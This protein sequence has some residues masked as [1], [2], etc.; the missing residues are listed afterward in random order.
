MRSVFLRVIAAFSLA[1]LVCILAFVWV[2]ARISRL[3]TGTLMQGS[4]ELELKQA[5]KAYEG[6]GPE[7]LKAYLQEVDASLKGT[8][9][10]TDA[11]GR[12]LVYG[13]DRSRMR[14]VEFNLFGLPKMRHGQLTVSTPSPDG[15]YSLILVAPPPFSLWIFVPFF[16]IVIVVTGAL[17]FG[18][19]GDIVSPLLRLAGTVDRFGRGDLSARIE[20]NRRDEFGTVARSFNSMADRIETLLTAERRLLQDVSHELRSP[21]ARLSFATELLKSTDDRDVAIARLRRESDRLNRLVSALLEMSAAEG[22]PASRKHQRVDIAELVREIVEDC[23]IEASARDL[24]IESI[25]EPAVVDGDSELLR[26][27][28]EN[29]LRNAIRYSSSGG[30]V[31]LNLT[32]RDTNAEITVRDFGPG[33][34]EQK[35]GRIFDPFFR[36]DDARDAGNGGVGLGLSIARRAIVLHHGTVIAHN[37]SPGLEVQITIPTAFQI[38]A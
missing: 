4:S 15:K 11:Q 14:K 1:L 28:V 8:R 32:W 17:A 34:D 27:A 23:A 18:L 13:T 24:H 36:A 37:A 31:L 30:K 2:A 21:L 19:S 12:D 5:R 7:Q 25:I 22:D 33:V 16:V 6:G 38:V 35:L 20:M 3:T 9:Y 10:L 29:V 26:R